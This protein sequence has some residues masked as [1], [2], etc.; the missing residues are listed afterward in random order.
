MT[1]MQGAPEMSSGC[2]YEA[3]G[4]LFSPRPVLMNQKGKGTIWL[5]WKVFMEQNIKHLT[6]PQCA[7]FSSQNMFQPGCIQRSL[8]IFQSSSQGWVGREFLKV[9]LFPSFEFC[10]C[11]FLNSFGSHTIYKCVDWVAKAGKARRGGDRTH[12]EHRQK[13]GR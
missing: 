6:D 2:C 4:S 1:V 5:R 3:N 7:V 11:L 9:H 8:G 12:S 13:E 10:W